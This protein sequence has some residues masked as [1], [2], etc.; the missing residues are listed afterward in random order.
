[1]SFNT[2]YRAQLYKYEA[3][4]NR[5]ILSDIIAFTLPVD[6]PL[7]NQDDPLD[8]SVYAGH[9]Y[10]WQ[11]TA[12]APGTVTYHWDFM[13]LDDDNDKLGYYRWDPFVTV[14]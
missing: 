3:N 6:L 12:V 13:I 8:P 10:F 4:D 1:M 2:R 11:A 5:R 9:D 14:T 7:P